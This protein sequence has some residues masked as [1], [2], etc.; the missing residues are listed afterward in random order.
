MQ[1][2]LTLYNDI[3]STNHQNEIFTY[4][5]DAVHNNQI[6]NPTEFYN[7]S[8][9]QTVYVKITNSDGCE[10]TFNPATGDPLTIEIRV[11]TSTI[12]NTFLET[13]YA[14]LDPSVKI[15]T[16]ISTFDKV[17]FADLEATLIAEHPAF[18]NNNV[19]I[20]FFETESDAASKI[21]PIDTSQNYIN[22]TPN[23]QQIC[24]LYTSDAADE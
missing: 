21:S 9:N 10:R 5:T 7:T 20:Q 19:T 12:K 16:G 13:Y 4:Y 14:C 24:L 22:S 3:F 6:I 1:D 17:V 8:M 23:S 11:R 2:N 18:V 15:N